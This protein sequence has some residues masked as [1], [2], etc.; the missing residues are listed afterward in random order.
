MS[1]TRS[2]LTLLAMLTLSLAPGAASTRADCDIDPL[3]LLPGDTVC[4]DA[5]RDGSPLT[6]YTYEE[7]TLIING[8]AALYELYGFEAA[9]FQNYEIDVGGSTASATLALFDQGTDA[10]AIALYTDPASGSGDPVAG[11]GGTGEA[12]LKT[13]LFSQTIQ[14]RE[15]CVFGSLTVMSTSTAALDVT[16]CLGE[17]ICVEIQQQ[18]DIQSFSFGGLKAR[19]K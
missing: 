17:A 9:A 15:E 7:L 11:W 19:Y 6:A 10:N 16:L 18:I 13:E 14:F 2:R 5:V 12:R 1:S 4:I 3:T 8:A